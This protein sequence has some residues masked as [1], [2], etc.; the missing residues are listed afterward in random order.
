MR[1]HWREST[2]LT[3]S[4]W[5]SIG[6]SSS[7]SGSG[8]NKKGSDDNGGDPL[9][10]D[11]SMGDATPN[12]QCTIC[13]QAAGKQFRCHHCAVPGGSRHH[14]TG[15]ALAEGIDHSDDAYTRGL[16]ASGDMKPIEPAE[17]HGGN[18]AGEQHGMGNALVP[19]CTSSVKK[20]TGRY[21]ITMEGAACHGKACCG[22]I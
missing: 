20:C 3:P 5:T 22:G 12:E 21:R 1:Q 9:G 11:G 17:P 15:G 7:S 2:G 18:E 10:M 8:M 16:G 19:K 4:N 6:G 14:S 13:N